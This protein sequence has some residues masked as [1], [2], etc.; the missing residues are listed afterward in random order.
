MKKLSDIANTGEEV[1]LV[2]NSVEPCKVEKGTVLYQCK[3]EGFKPGNF[4]YFFKRCDNPENL[5]ILYKKDISEIIREPVLTI[6]IN[7][8][9]RMGKRYL[10][11]L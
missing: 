9:K 6:K 8:S 3:S 1:T 10:G 4:G 2:D 7:S 5:K 11:N